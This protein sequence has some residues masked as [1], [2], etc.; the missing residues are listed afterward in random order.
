MI[1]NILKICS[2]GKSIKNKDS[3][4]I[5]NKKIKCMK[6]FKSR[7]SNTLVKSNQSI[8]N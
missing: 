8:I 6:I 5:K 4:N 7:K 1:N 3:N 2:N